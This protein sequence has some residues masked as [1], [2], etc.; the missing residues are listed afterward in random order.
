MPTTPYTVTR[1]VV[2]DAPAERIFALI[3]NFHHWE[4][5]SPWED[6]DPTM[7]RTY[8]GPDSGDGATYAWK[9]NRKAGEGSM[10]ITNSR[11]PHRVEIALRF[12]KPFPADN[13]VALTLE[14]AGES[15]TV[16]WTMSG[17]QRGIMAVAGRVYPMDKMIGKDFDKG[18]AR[19]KR[20]AER[21]AG[22][23]S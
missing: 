17:A 11:E 3:D 9:G 2:I 21:A 7:S 1:R 12:L 5:W 18:L 10:R 22:R 19:L 6:I 16:T 8:S 13:R 23:Q 15:T 4:S 20:V 14:P